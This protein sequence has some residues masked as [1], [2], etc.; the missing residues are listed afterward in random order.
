VIELQLR[1]KDP[2][3]ALVAVLDTW[4]HFECVRQVNKP[5]TFALRLNGDDSRVPLFELD[6]QIEAWWKDTAQG[7]AWR[8]EL[9][10]FL[11]DFVPY[12]DT[13][14]QKHL[15]PSGN[16]YL[17]LLGR[18]IVDTYAGS[19][20]SDKSGPGETVLKEF[21]DEQA[22]PGA[23][24]RARTGLAIEA[25]TAMGEI[26]QGQRSNDNLLE[27]CQEIARGTGLEFDI[28]GTGPGSF[29]FQVFAG[30]DRTATVIFS[31]ERGNMGQAQMTQ[32]YSRVRNAVKVGGQG[33]GLAR[34]YR[35]RTDPVSMA[36]SPWG[37]RELFLNASNQ[38]STDKLDSQGDAKLL[39]SRATQGLSF[40]TI[41]TPACR[42]GQ[43]YFLGDLVLARYAGLN[44]LKRVDQVH[45]ISDSSGTKLDVSM[46]DEE[47]PIGS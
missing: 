13:S 33:V 8:K 38:D 1:V 4:P 44:F 6:G 7:I 36:L 15:I 12:T 23:G 16:G 31:E 11:E 17:G 42:Y 3:G 35:W 10:A 5:A 39:E 9:E 43:H 32:Q 22:G 30:T 46:I 2:A 37:R 28:I 19:P 47:P 20:D 21:V 14:G 45:W 41:Q 25:D 24:A 27:L 29:E 18:T 34:T 26:W 40:T